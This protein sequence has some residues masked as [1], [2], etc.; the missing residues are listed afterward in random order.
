MNFELSYLQSNSCSR[1]PKSKYLFKVRDG[2]NVVK[3]R[4]VNKDMLIILFALY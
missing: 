3:F 1:N 2:G 4:V